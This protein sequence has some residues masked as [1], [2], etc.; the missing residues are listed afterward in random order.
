MNDTDIE[1]LGLPERCAHF[2][3]CS[4]NKCPLDPLINIR[5]AD[6]S[7]PTC[8][9]PKSRRHNYWAQMLPKEQALLPFKGYFEGEYTRK[10]AWAARWN[11][12]SQKEKD[13]ALEKLAQLRLRRRKLQPIPPNQVIP[14]T[15]PPSVP[16][17]TKM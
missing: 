1:K 4:A 2:D 16:D 7:D 17:S 13:T 9:M 5:N 10:Q 11:A 6:P 12:L 8:D 15:P 3:S 14:P